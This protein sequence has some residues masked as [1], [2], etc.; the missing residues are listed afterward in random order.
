MKRFSFFI[1]FLTLIC[2]ISFTACSQLAS[3]HDGSSNN[4]FDGTFFNNLAIDPNGKR[5]ATDFLTWFFNRQA[6]PWENLAVAT[7]ILQKQSQA[8]RITWVNHATVLIQ[9]NNVNILTD[10]IWSERASPFTWVGPKRK[11]PTVIDIQDLPPIDVVLIS[12][13]HYDHMD[14][15]SLQA[16]NKIFKPRFIVPLGNSHYLN[17]AGISHITELDWWDSFTLK[18]TNIIATPAQHWSKRTL[19]DANRS[20]WAGFYIKAL[21]QSVFFAGDTAYEKHFKLVNTKLGPP[22]V[23]LLPIGAYK[24]R[25]FMKRAH[26]NPEEAVLAHIDLGAIRSIPI[27][28][29]TFQLGDDSPKSALSDLEKAVKQFSVKETAFKAILPGQT[30]SME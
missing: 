13:N 8:L 10:P 14:I 7:P 15:P 5:S 4:H 21:N 25:W 2:V 3:R 23:A 24:P 18:G 20:L 16:L 27:H 9:L 30:Y 6:E 22:T 17:D 1:I 29:D 19:F 12:H 26:T 11:T 28:Y